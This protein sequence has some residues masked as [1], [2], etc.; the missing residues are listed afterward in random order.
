M[1]HWWIWKKKKVSSTQQVFKQDSNWCPQNSMYIFTQVK[2]IP[3]TPE[4]MMSNAINLS[5]FFFIHLDNKLKTT[6]N[7][8]D[9]F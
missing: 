2:V 8:T 4:L 7:V 1:S 9:T 6:N 5:N 3:E